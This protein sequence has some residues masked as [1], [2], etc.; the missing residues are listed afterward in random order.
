MYRRQVAAF[1]RQFINP[2]VIPKRSDWPDLNFSFSTNSSVRRRC[3][4]GARKRAVRREG[5]HTK[6]DTLINEAF[7][8]TESFLVRVV[9]FLLSQVIFNSLD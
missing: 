4:L 7:R 8:I 1:S 6:L 9:V 3:Q 5:R 2:W